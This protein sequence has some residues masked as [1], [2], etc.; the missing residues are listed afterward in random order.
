MRQRGGVIFEAIYYDV[1]RTS[2]VRC[3]PAPTKQMLLYC[4]FNLNDILEFPDDVS[5]VYCM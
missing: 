3:P 5:V 2:Y 4:P 1:V